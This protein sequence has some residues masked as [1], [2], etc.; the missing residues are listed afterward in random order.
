MC[1][2]FDVLYVVDPA[3]S[4]FGGLQNNEGLDSFN[5]ENSSIVSSRS[6]H[7]N[8]QGSSS[9]GVSSSGRGLSLNGESPRKASLQYY[10]RRIGQYTR[11]YKHVLMLVRQGFG[12]NACVAQMFLLKKG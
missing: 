2:D 4:W 10:Q 8:H 6:E 5:S 7:M 11:R 3:R 9:M 12:K 1:R